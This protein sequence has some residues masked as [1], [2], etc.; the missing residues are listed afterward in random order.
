M[1]TRTHGAAP[2]VQ[3]AL[4][5]FLLVRRTSPNTRVVRRRLDQGHTYTNTRGVREPTPHTHTHT[6][7]HKHSSSCGRPTRTSLPEPESIL[8]TISLPPPPSRT[9]H[10]VFHSL[11]Q[12]K[13]LHPSNQSTPSW[14]TRQPMRHTKSTHFFVL[15]SP[16][17]LQRRRPNTRVTRD[18]RTASRTHSRTQKN[19]QPG[20]AKKRFSPSPSPSLPSHPHPTTRETTNHKDTTPTQRNTARPHPHALPRL[21][22]LLRLLSLSLSFSLSLSP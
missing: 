19:P 16:L 12:T 13:A 8:Q 3:H 2:S 18:N 15:R 7:A 5:A 21:V 14:R 22:V 17:C 4:H 20:S 6:H 10:I 11:S 9:E 1:H